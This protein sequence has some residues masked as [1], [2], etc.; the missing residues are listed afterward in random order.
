MA[1]NRIKI[2]HHNQFHIYGENRCIHPET[3]DFCDVFPDL[4]YIGTHD[5]SVNARKKKLRNLPAR[6]ISLSKIFFH[7]LN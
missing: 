2:F 1:E 3:I 7:L 6:Q 5:Q 4:I